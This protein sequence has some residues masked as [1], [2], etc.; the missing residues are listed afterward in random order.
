MI[1]A[2]KLISPEVLNTIGS[3]LSYGTIGLGLGLALFATLAKIITKTKD[4][5][6]MIFAFGLVIIGAVIELVRNYEF[7]KES[8]RNFYALQVLPDELWD[9]FLETRMR[10]EFSISKPVKDDLNG[11]LNDNETIPFNIRIP[12][13]E[14]RYYFVATKPPSQITVKLISLDVSRYIMPSR[15]Y[16]KSERLCIENGEGGEINLSATMH[17][18]GAQFSIREMIAPVEPTQVAN[19]APPPPPGPPPPPSPPQPDF[20]KVACIGEYQGAC[21]GNNDVWIGCSAAPDQQ[22]ASQLC[23][24]EVLKSKRRLLT[25]GGN[26][27]GYALIEATCAHRL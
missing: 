11:W 20:V 27:C 2:S 5:E 6:F 21:P 1:G 9:D 16:Y 23:G 15:P 7:S 24:V 22:I 19:V 10:S 12:K 17:N 14:C 26:A 25:T 8:E 13:N 4:I 3:Y 18:G